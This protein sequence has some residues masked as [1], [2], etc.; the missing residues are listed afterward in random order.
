MSFCAAPKPAIHTIA[1]PSSVILA[2]LVAAFALL[3][4][5][6][7]DDASAQGFRLQGARGGFV[8]SPRAMSSRSGT[9]L[10]KSGQRSRGNLASGPSHPPKGGMGMGGMGGR[11]GG[12]GGMGGGRHPSDTADIPKTHNPKGR[13]PR[14]RW[15]HRP[16][17]FVP[18]DVVVAVPGGPPSGPPSNG[19]GGRPPSNPPSSQS[20]RGAATPPVLGRRY[21]PNEVVV[22]VA[23]NMSPQAMTALV[24]RHRLTQLEAI[25]LQTSGTSIRRLRINNRRSVPAVVRAL[26]A[27]GAVMTVQPNYIAT[28]QEAS[29][30]N[31]FPADLEP[32][33][34][35]R[36]RM[37]EAHTLATGD[38]VLV[39]VID[40][41][42]DTQHPEL[43]GMILDTFDAIGTGDRVHP[44]GTA[45]VGL[46]AARARLRGTAPA[47]HFLVA[48]AFAT[49]RNSTDG[50]STNI[51]KA[52]DW[53]I[54]R[55]A[56]V[57]NMSFAGDRDPAIEKLLAAA[58]SRGIVLVAA[59]GNAGPNSRPLYPA[60]NPS[61]IAVTATDDQ[62]RI[63]RAANRGSHV[64]VAAP[65]VDLWVLTLGGDY[66][67]TSGTSFSSAEI[68]GVV[69]LMLERN[70]GLTPAAVRR[71]LMSTA[72]DLGP[73]G[74][75]ATFGA[76]LV[77]AYQAVLSVVP[78]AAAATTAG[79]EN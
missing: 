46:M 71:A 27:E 11:G 59:A 42:V 54:Q 13:W 9:V 41:G 67:M 38:R 23:A 28:L 34:P 26:A 32:Y 57:I 56:R 55:G 36:L 6:A 19:S 15:P 66:R 39:A 8:H 18:G 61:V 33:A 17:I 45:I 10:N 50:T 58:S 48:R 16:P 53:A 49:R 25:N 35:E 43:A 3:M 22:E 64:A 70:P 12:M 68:S 1:R 20:G 40:S 24:L 30:R 37:S 69:A 77:D 60:A 21:V 76:G 31:S 29:A 7:I 78:A 47:A 4:P 44:H 65:G 74:M 2:I 79:A 73:R 63:F 72:R 52:L 5:P 75:D 51:V 62:D 14:P